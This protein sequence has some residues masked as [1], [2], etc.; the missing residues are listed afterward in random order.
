MELVRV[1]EAAAVAAA[2]WMGRGDKIGADQAAVDAMRMMLDTVDMDGVIVIGEGEKDEAP[3]LFNGERVGNGHG[4]QVDVAVDPLEGTRLTAQGRPGAVSVIA[5]APRGTLYDPHEMFYMEKIAVGPQARGAIDL[6]APVDWNIRQVARAKGIPV[7]EVTVIILDRDR[8]TDIADQ[9]RAAGARIKFITDGDAPAAVSAGIPSAGVDM[10]LGIGGSPEGVVAACALKCLEGDFQGRLW[11]R[12]DDDRRLAEERGIDLTK[13][14]R[15]ED[16]VKGDDVFFAATGVT[17]GDLLQGV[18]YTAGGA[19][20]ESL[21]MRSRS[22]T[23]RR[24][25]TEHHWRKLQGLDHTVN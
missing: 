20:S 22:G 4:P 7:E 2:K 18:E 3:M 6:S 11:P 23:I 15:I 9:V 16:L 19:V 5:C 1:T 10:M 14:L 8:N 12:N 13:V 21:V 25:R 24:I 17:G